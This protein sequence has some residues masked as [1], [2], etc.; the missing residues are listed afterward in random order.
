MVTAAGC[1]DA[2]GVKNTQ[3]F[4]ANMTGNAVLLASTLASAA[5][6]SQA[7]DTA[8][9]LVSFCAGCA[10][11]S[12]V[13][14]LLKLKCPQGIDGIPLAI[15]LAGWLLVSCGISLLRTPAPHHF[16]TGHLFTIAAAMGIQ[17][18]AAL[19][20]SIPGAGVTTVITS[21]LTAAIAQ[22]TGSLQRFIFKKESDHTEAFTPFPLLVFACY[23]LGAFLGVFPLGLSTAS[24]IL[25][26]GAVLAGIGITIN[27]IPKNEDF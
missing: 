4:P 5:P 7:K 3:I 23:L 17:S 8:L 18:S 12:L 19:A 14:R 10:L 2:I 11:A 27:F 9:T 26:A 13:I 24:T 22:I 25:L 6:I 1:V 16:S 21:T 20:M 15:Q